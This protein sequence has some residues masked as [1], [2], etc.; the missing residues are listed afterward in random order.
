MRSR[1]RFG[2]WIVIVPVAILALLSPVSQVKA[3]A[4]GNW[5]YSQSCV[6]SGSIEV[7]DDAIVLHGPDYGGCSGAANWVKIESVIPEG[8]NTVDFT[9]AYQTTDGAW[10]DPPQYAV[11]GAYVMLTQQNNAT[12]SLSVPVVEGDV[13]TF[14]QYSTDTCCAPG[15]LTISNLSL[16][17]ASETTTTT[18]STTTSSS[19]PQTTSSE[20]TTTTTQP[21]QTTTSTTLGP[22][23]TTAEPQTTTSVHQTTSS[24]SSSSSSQ[25]QTTTTLEETTTTSVIPVTIP[26][27]PF[28]PP[29]TVFVPTGTTTTLVEA[30]IE[31]SLPEEELPSTIEMPVVTDPLIELPTTIEVVPPVQDNNL[32]EEVLPIEVVLP[33]VGPQLEDLLPAEPITDA[34]LDAIITESFTPEATAEEV[35]AAIDTILTSDVTFAQ[36]ESVVDAV[37]TEDAT[38]EVMSAAL[39]SLV[40]ADLSVRELATVLDAVFDSDLSDEATIALAEEILEQPLSAEEFK[41]VLYAIFDE[42]VADEILVATFTAVL[43]T[44]LTEERFAEVVNV[45]SSDAIT[46]DQVAQVV[47]LI[48]GQEDGVAPEQ[49][50]ELVSSAKVLESVTGDQAT[51]VF[52]SVDEGALTAENGEQITAAVQE[53]PVAVRDAFQEEINV[54]GGV[55]DGYYP[56]GSMVDVGTRRVVVAGTGVLLSAPVLASRRV[57]V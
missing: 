33:E 2:S 49:A 28:T 34:V 27:I 32:V 38:V 52:G 1:W 45:L 48:I 47:D 7:I 42:K 21:L 5:T 56:L 24:S 44:P 16:W 43:D 22:S 8:I 39:E 4:L 23:T 57:R 9:W 30:P 50:V 35:S 55:F 10:Y 25:P 3:D 15:H 13:F 41:T 14:R 31:I 17:T 46:N 29:T 12:G 11:N 53:A 54:F 26:T 19:L 20:S 40:D 18:T 51:E 6:Q 36:L 37:F